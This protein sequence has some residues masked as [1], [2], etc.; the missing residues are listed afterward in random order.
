MTSVSAGSKAV[1]TQAFSQT[2]AAKGLTVDPDQKPVLS[3][4]DRL[5]Q[6]LTQSN[7]LVASPGVFTQLLG[8]LA[9]RTGH[10]PRGIYLWG[11]V[12]RGKTMIMDV[13]HQSLAG[14]RTRRTHFH[15]F[16][17][18]VHQRLRQL[19]DQKDPLRQISRVISR[20]SRELLVLLGQFLILS[21][22]SLQL[23]D[24]CC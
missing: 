20:E 9:Q 15:R 14:P 4:F 2:L 7:H 5:Y 16:M 19:R 17:L 22:Q 13:F 1:A 18:E 23:R 10:S 24:A 8:R 6:E 11:G 12:G 21:S 3:Q